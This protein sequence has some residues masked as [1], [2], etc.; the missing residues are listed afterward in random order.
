MSTESKLFIPKDIKKTTGIITDLMVTEVGNLYQERGGDKITEVLERYLEASS[1]I[2][3][4]AVHV[5]VYKTEEK[6]I[7]RFTMN[8][9]NFINT[10]RNDIDNWSKLWRNIAE[11]RWMLNTEAVDLVWLTPG[12]QSIYA[13]EIPGMEQFQIDNIRRSI[14]GTKYNSMGGI[15]LGD[16]LAF[17]KR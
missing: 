13:T 14:I 6:D 16:A 10:K 12:G 3:D 7:P 5:E 2:S 4:S 1:E 15:F 9:M 8:A 11:L 17:V